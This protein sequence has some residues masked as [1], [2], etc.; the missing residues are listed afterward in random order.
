MPKKAK[1]APETTV[2]EVAEIQRHNQLLTSLATALNHLLT[3]N[4]GVVI[5]LNG[6]LHIVYRDT[7]DNIHLEPITS[8]DQLVPGSVLNINPPQADE[9]DPAAEAPAKDDSQAVTYDALEVADD[10]VM[11]EAAEKE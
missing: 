2:V 11:E 5:V 9:A 3:P 6:Q 7:T 10:A 1:N 8:N 4:Q